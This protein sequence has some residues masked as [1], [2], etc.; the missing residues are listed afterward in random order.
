ME[1]PPL[2]LSS[3]MK[4]LICGVTPAFRSRLVAVYRPQ[5][6]Q[7]TGPAALKLMTVPFG[8]LLNEPVRVAAPQLGAAINPLVKTKRMQRRF[9]GIFYPLSGLYHRI[10]PTD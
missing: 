4:S 2:V 6:T 1:T 8:M 10:L 9:E 5:C 7:S 3:G